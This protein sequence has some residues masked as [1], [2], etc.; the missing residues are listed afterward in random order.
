[1]IQQFRERNDEDLAHINIEDD[2]NVRPACPSSG[3]G[4]F[5]RHRV[6]LNPIITKNRG[7]KS[8]SE[9][10]FNDKERAPADV[11]VDKINNQISK[12]DGTASPLSVN[13]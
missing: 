12:H 10:I 2:H 9:S 13:K 1:M 7:N 4:Y 3:P 8:S 5:D 11:N 6:K